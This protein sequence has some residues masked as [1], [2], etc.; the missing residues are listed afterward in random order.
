MP[1]V[2]VS[3]IQ[4]ADHPTYVDPNIE[5]LV[6][7]TAHE[8]MEMDNPISVLVAPSHAPIIS[9]LLDGGPPNQFIAKVLSLA[10]RHKKG[11]HV[12]CKATLI[13]RYDDKGKTIE[14]WSALCNHCGQC[15]LNEF[16]EWWTKAPS[17]IRQLFY[18]SLALFPVPA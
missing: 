17:P 7:Y 15:Q 18:D 5:A 4:G 3:W 9:G 10:L 1:P 13:C 11:H 2:E 12:C 16:E 14:T 6:G 8:V